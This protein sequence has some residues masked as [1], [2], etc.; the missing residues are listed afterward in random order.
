MAERIWHFEVENVIELL[1][2]QLRR[3]R[4]HRR[5]FAIRIEVVP[6]L[7]LTHIE[8]V[9]LVHQLHEQNVLVIVTVEHLNKGH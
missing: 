2:P 1:L 9:N 6:R 5:G 7:L 8:L 3:R 4:Q